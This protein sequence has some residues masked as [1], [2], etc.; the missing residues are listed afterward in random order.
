MSDYCTILNTCPDH[1]TGEQ[2]AKLLV[3]Q[4]LAACVNLID[5][6]SSI[7]RW[8]DGIEQDRETLL[9]IKTKKEHY[10]KIEDTIQQHHPYKVPEE[11]ALDISQGSDNYLNWITQTTS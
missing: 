8:E 3:E 11:I 2:I 9:V 4:Q 5:N 6:I 7:Y 10:Q 1:E